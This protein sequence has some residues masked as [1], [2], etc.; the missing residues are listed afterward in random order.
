MP[1]TAGVATGT[2][3]RP[4]PS[5]AA[6]A[7]RAGSRPAPGGPRRRGRPRPS[8]RCRAGA[9]TGP[10]PGDGERDREIGAGLRDADRRRRRWRRRR[11]RRDRGAARCC[12]HREQQRQ[13]V[14][15]RR[16]SR[17]GGATRRRS[18]AATSACTSTSSGRAPST[19]GATTEPGAPAQRSAR[20]SAD[21]SG[22]P[23]S[24]ASV[25]S[26]SPSS[27]VDPN[28]CFDACEEA[29]ARGAG[30]PRTSTR[31][32]R[33]AR[34]CAARRGEPSLVTWPTRSVVTPC[35]LASRTSRC[36]HS[37]TCVTEP[38]TPG[39]SG[40]RR[41]GSSR[42]R[43]RRVGASRRGRA[44]AASTSRR[45]AAAPAASAPR[46]PARSRTCSA[47]SSAPTSRQRAP[48]AARRP[49]DW[50]SSV[51]LPMPGSPPSRVHRPGDEPAAEH[52]VELVDAGRPPGRARAGRR[53]PEGTTGAPPTTS[54]GARPGTGPDLDQRPPGP[55]LR[56]APEPP[57][58]PRPRTRCSGGPLV[59]SRSRCSHRAVDAERHVARGGCDSYGPE[60]WPDRA[61]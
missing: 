29:R 41:P 57:R 60:P 23:S 31:C 19:T 47:D 21:G 5:R 35:S 33:R 6:S 25:I 10:R 9:Q 3:A 26:N 50:S 14:R 52:P 36:A 39:R 16:R 55:A 59:L 12:E 2:I 34:A 37:R 13:P 27:W 42:R 44:R 4:K 11:G 46:R 53:R 56:A 24:P 17:P 18:R 45:R 61:P 51:L 15:R 22:T 32:R 1:S 54:T 30:R 40:S 38:G 48:A 28:R 20:N 8:P 43:R 7:S 49:S 58:A